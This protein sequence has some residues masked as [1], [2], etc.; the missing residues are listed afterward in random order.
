MALAH[1]DV[2]SSNR[3]TIACDH[4]IDSLNDADLALKVRERTPKT[5]DDCLFVSQQLEAW[6]RDSSRQKVEHSQS[7]SN[8]FQHVL[9]IKN[10]SVTNKSD[11]NAKIDAFAIQ[12]EH[13]TKQVAD[14]QR[15]QVEQRKPFYSRYSRVDQ[16]I[17]S[18]Q[19]GCGN[20]GDRSHAVSSCPFLQRS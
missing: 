6:A 18:T 15:V 20:C 10:D 4:F 17:T 13:L 12:L 16:P 19:A 1:P 9:S 14:M 7:Q 8:Y 11:S 2:E 5:L 3:D